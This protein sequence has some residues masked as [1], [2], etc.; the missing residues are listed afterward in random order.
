MSH[1]LDHSK[2]YLTFNTLIFISHA[3]SPLITFPTGSI[4]N[5][6]AVVAKV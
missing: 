3:D 2:I 4:V 1:D 5:I 6:S